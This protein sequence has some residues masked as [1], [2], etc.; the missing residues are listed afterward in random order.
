MTPQNSK[1]Q[2][3]LN[4]EIRL[5]H[6]VPKECVATLTSFPEPGEISS[7]N[8][9]HTPTELKDT[10]LKLLPRETCRMHDTDQDIAGIRSSTVGQRICIEYDFLAMAKTNLFHGIIPM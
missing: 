7:W 10:H 9:T 8:G 5:G 3:N 6:I 1:H 2:P 4:H